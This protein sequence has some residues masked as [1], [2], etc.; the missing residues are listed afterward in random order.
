[1]TGDVGRRPFMHESTRRELA[2]LNI[3]FRARQLQVFRSHLARSIRLASPLLV[4]ACTPQELDEAIW[5]VKPYEHWPH[6]PD[7]R[8][9]LRGWS[10]TSRRYDRERVA[11]VNRVTG[12][13]FEVMDQLVV[14]IGRNAA[15]MMFR[16]G[17][18]SIITR[19]GGGVLSLPRGLQPAEREGLVGATL[20]MTVEHPILMGRPYSII[21]ATRPPSSDMTLLKFVAPPVEWRVP[22]ARP[23]EVP[24]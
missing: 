12:E 15:H 19:E 11:A 9:T 14:R 23:W 16:I 22:W 3:E 10:A 8:V 20:D 13:R 2:A 18:L 7:A 21:E 4:D 6:G 1:M 5:R 24:F 17:E